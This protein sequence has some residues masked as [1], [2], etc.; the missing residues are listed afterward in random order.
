[1]SGLFNHIAC[2]VDDSEASRRALE[3]AIRLAG[4][5]GRVSLVHV[6]QQP[7]LYPDPAGVML[8]EPE[9]VHERARRWLDRQAKAFPSTETVLLEGHA[10]TAV[11]VWADQA[12]P[13]L[14]VAAAHRGLIDRMLLGSFAGFLVRHS[15]A[16]VLLVR[17]DRALD[18][19]A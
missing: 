12:A 3:E 8:P 19:P 14:I 1:M 4:D 11:C 15:P 5:R 17:P 2:C 6:T 13:D 18:A 16:N 7:V 10:G 9:S